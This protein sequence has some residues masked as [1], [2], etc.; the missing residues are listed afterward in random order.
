VNYLFKSTDYEKMS[1]Y[2]YGITTFDLSRM[3]ELAQRLSSPHKALSFSHIAGTKGKG[4]VAYMLG[5][6][7]QEAGLKV[8]LFT[9]PHLVALEERMSINGEP[10]EKD[11]LRDLLNDAYETLEEM[12]AKWGERA[13]TFFEIITAL[14]LL[15]FARKNVDMVVLEVGLG[16]R[17]DSTNIVT[18]L[19]SS[20]TPISLDHTQLLGGTIE[21]IAYEKAGIIKKDVPVISAPQEPQALEVIEDIARKHGAPL[22][23]VG[24]EIEIIPACAG[25][26]HGTPGWAAGKHFGIKTWR[27][28]YNDL[29]L[30]LLGRHQRINA[31]V[32]IGMLEVLKEKGVLKIGE[33]EVKRALENIRIPGRIEVVSKKPTIVLDSAHNVASVQ[34]LVDALKEN[35]KW[36]RLILCFAAAKDK[37]IPGMLRLLIPFASEAIFTTTGNPRSASTEDL[38][39]AV[40]S[41]KAILLTQEEDPL[42][43]FELAEARARANDLILIT[44]SFYLAGKIKEGLKGP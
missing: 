40:S 13:P 30:P 7:L 3:E 33:G 11:A 36:E 18:P 4:S 43:A 21:K 14:A 41:F 19:A 20:V 32:A 34:D 37:D 10:I 2:R 17:L 5:A 22:Y 31:A 6:I 26:P 44:G 23:L 29:S 12:K 25:H 24:R 15:Y 39:E 42:R 9:S 28:E 16:G 38:A 35:L 8:G 27:D 1:T